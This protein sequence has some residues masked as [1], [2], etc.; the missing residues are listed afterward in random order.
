MSKS[1][2]QRHPYAEGLT[3]TEEKSFM[4]YNLV[5][6]EENIVGMIAYCFY[7][8]SKIE[9]IKQF[10]EKNNG[11][12]P[13]E[14]N[15][16]GFQEHQCTPS[17]I[18]SYKAQALQLFE[19]WQ[20]FLYDDFFKELHRKEKQLKKDQKELNELAKKC[21]A[22]KTSSF[23]SSVW[24]S[25]VATLILGI[26]GLLIWITQLVPTVHNIIVRT[27]QGTNSVNIIKK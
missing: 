1:K 18:S 19:S 24:A 22:K 26:V 23:G 4:F 3:E 2:V 7:K 5:K 12:S 17:T 13:N 9:F 16:K 8:N 14:E 21:P 11:I 6:S 15:L 25:I 20:A 10:K 27:F